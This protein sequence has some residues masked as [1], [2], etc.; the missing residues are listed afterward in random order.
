[1]DDLLTS[2]GYALA[3]SAVG[4]VILAI[5][6]VA[7]DVLTP[8]RLG[9][10]IMREGSVNAAIVTAA[11]LVGLGFIV[12]TAIWSNGDSSFGHALGWTITFGLLGVI[13]QAVAFR[14]LDLFLPDDLAAIVM[15][16]EFHPA[17]IVA[18]ASQIAVSLV[19]VACVA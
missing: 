13:M 14:L 11:G 12:F 8:G 6:Y 16:K 5:G 1:M 7:L 17:S 10:H 3:Y 15:R 19:I 9:H 4:I 2:V 18:A